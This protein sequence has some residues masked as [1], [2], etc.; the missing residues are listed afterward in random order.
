[1]LDP[2]PCFYPLIYIAGCLILLSVVALVVLWMR[3]RSVLDLWLMVVICAFAIEIYLVSFPAPVRF[4]M[5]WYAGR[6]YNLSQAFS[7]FLSCC[8]R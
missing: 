2:H 6:V 3:L 8:T 1:M 5:G 7:Y 4:S